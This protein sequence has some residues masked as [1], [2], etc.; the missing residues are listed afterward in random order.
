MAHGKRLARA[1][2]EPAWSIVIVTALCL[3]LTAG[4][5]R[6]VVELLDLWSAPDGGI[7][8]V[9]VPMAPPSVSGAIARHGED[10]QLELE[11]EPGR[12]VLLLVEGR[13]PIEITLD[14]R[15]RAAVDGK[16]LPPDLS[17]I[18]L[19]LLPAEQATVIPPTATPTPSA[20]PEPSATR[21]P[22][23]TSPPSPTLTPTSEPTLAPSPTTVPT[24]AI[25]QKATHT[26]THSPTAPRRRTTRAA[27][28]PAAPVP[29]TTRAVQTGPT[30]SDVRDAPP[31][32]HLVTDAG[33][34]LA[35]T[36]DGASS[37][38]GTADLLELLNR[39]DLK[40]TIFVTGGFVDDYPSL[41]RLALL[42]GHEIG[43]HTYSHPH[44]TSYPQNHRHDTLPEVNREW[45][46]D[47]LRRTEEAFRRATG[48]P[49]APLWRAPYGEENAQLRGWA[50]ELGYLHIRWS[51]LQGKSLDSLDWVEDEHSSL[52]FKSSRLVDRLLAFPELEGGIV[53]MHLATK[54][55][56][57]PWSE[58]PRFTEEVSRRGVSVGS[59]TDLLEHSN[60][61]RPWLE[62]ARARHTEVFGGG[63]EP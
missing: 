60:Q 24:A 58:L 49:M 37:S 43:N 55:A 19:A 16:E 53:L 40:V 30:R 11:G 7:V 2:I 51:S 27:P 42:A 1:P 23:P 54:R 6:L 3:M 28:S 22:K 45:F 29:T 59:V 62:R 14:R 38:R 57:P 8:E 52:Y 41:V 48:R 21:T 47:Q 18:R 35:L 15:G 33:P 39:L 46:L 61:W 26:A 34:R 13:P 31:V 5:T 36:F 12:V 20:I 56:V 63:D 32:L 9:A 4:I 10:W 17:S 50:M 44:L 25:T